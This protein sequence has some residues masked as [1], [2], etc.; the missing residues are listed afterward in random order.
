M[1]P[2]GRVKAAV[3]RELDKLTHWRFM[4]VQTGYGTPA[5]DF[6]CCINGW[7][8][9][10]ETKKDAKAKLTDRQLATKKDMEAAGGIVLVIYDQ[11]SL[12]RAVKI[13]KG[14]C[15]GHRDYLVTADVSAEAAR[16]EQQHLRTEQQGETVAKATGRH[17][18][19]PRKKPDGRSVAGEGQPDQRV[20]ATVTRL[21]PRCGGDRLVYDNDP[22]LKS[23]HEMLCGDF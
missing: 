6:I 19:A 4:P 2:E 10:I 14:I 18:G 5:L 12:E 7:F 9:A 8:V 22:E 16:Q 20:T 1:T 17:H 21:C 11:E 3:K 23:Q 15:N 13:I